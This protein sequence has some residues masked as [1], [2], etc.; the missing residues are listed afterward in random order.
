MGKNEINLKSKKKDKKKRETNRPKKVTVNSVVKIRVFFVCLPKH[1]WTIKSEANR[2]SNRART[3]FAP[4]LI[5]FA[6]DLIDLGPIFAYGLFLPTVREFL[7]SGTA[8]VVVPL[9]CRVL[10]S[11]ITTLCALSS[12]S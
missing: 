8:L 5:D 10:H 9:L 12:V 3:N 7:K 6:P 11:H 2:Q 1:G 4:D